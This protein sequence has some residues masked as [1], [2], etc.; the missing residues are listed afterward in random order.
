MQ[1]PRGF[2]LFQKLKHTWRVVGFSDARFESF[3]LPI[4][5]EQRVLLLFLKR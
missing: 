1:G 4:G 2:E 5:E 3:T